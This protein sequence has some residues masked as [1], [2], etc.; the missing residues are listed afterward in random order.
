MVGA[1]GH[2]PARHTVG[3]VMQQDSTGAWHPLLRM[4]EDRFGTED[5]PIVVPS[6][7]AERIIGVTDPEDDNLVVSKGRLCQ[8]MW[9]VTRV[10]ILLAVGCSWTGPK[11]PGT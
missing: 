10:A 1:F 8:I 11:V 4:Y 3:F 2:Q 7:E 6:L 5:S 9:L